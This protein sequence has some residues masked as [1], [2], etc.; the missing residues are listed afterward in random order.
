MMGFFQE[1]HE[2][3]RFEKSVNAL[4]ITLVPKK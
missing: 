4:F 1:F 2:T 3:C